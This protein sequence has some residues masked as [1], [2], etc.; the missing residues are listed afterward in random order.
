M[1]RYIIFFLLT[2]LQQCLCVDGWG[3]GVLTQQF[4]DLPAADYPVTSEG[5]P[6]YAA[7]F[8]VN[9]PAQSTAKVHLEFPEYT[10]LTPAE[11]KLIETAGWG[12]AAA[13]VPNYYTSYSRRLDSND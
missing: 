13:P 9:L 11:Q 2:C 3:Q 1:K 7:Q 12:V 5:L 6:T 4:V 8:A 10:P